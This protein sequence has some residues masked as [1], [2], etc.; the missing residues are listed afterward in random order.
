MM[1]RHFRGIALAVLCLLDF[2]A[3]AQTVEPD[4]TRPLRMES[5]TIGERGTEE[6]IQFDRPISHERSSLFLVHNGK[7]IETIHPRLEASPKVLFARIQTPT[8]GTYVLR[9]TVCPQGS[10][11][12]YDGEFPFKVGQVATSAGE[13]RQPRSRAE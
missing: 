10:N 12:R 7:V 2:Q 8:P 4:T 9:W 6:F 13:P 3:H 5:V 11:D 1:A